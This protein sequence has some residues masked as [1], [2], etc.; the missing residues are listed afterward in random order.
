MDL[1]AERPEPIPVLAEMSSTNPLF[2]LPGALRERGE[3]I[4]SGLAG[5]FT[6]GVGQFCTKPGLVFVEK[7]AHGDGFVAKV[8]EA[9]SKVDPG[10]L[11]TPGIATSYRTGVANRQSETHLLAGDAATKGCGASPAVFETTS[12][13]LSGELVEELFGPTVLIVRCSGL[14]EMLDFA[15]R[16]TG[17]LTATLQ[18]TEADLRESSELV[19]ALLAKVG[20]V[21]FNGF[22]TGV[23]VSPAMVHGGT[24]PATSD[25]RFTS[26]GTLAIHRFARPVC[27]QNFPDNSLPVELKD[28]NPLDILRLVDGQSTRDKITRQ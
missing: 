14:Q 18:G 8:V 22:P 1:A 11:L 27:F 13:A 25:S 16:M 12:D 19:E 24:Y 9:A 2:V 15:G 17:Q 4:A 3:G 6:L 28:A 20:R 7:G 10:T 21:I 5:S 26:V 23:E